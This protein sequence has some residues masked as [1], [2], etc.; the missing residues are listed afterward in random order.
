MVPKAV[1]PY[2]NSD[3][4][5]SKLSIRVLPFINIKNDTLPSTQMAVHSYELTRTLEVFDKY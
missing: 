5:H 3:S 2:P 4:A 1:H